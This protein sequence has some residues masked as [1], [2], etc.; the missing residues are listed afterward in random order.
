MSYPTPIY[1]FNHGATADKAWG[2]N[3]NNPTAILQYND[4]K[5]LPVALRDK[6]N[7]YVKAVHQNNLTPVNAAAT[8][9]NAAAVNASMLEFLRLK[10]VRG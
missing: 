5:D 8:R 10:Q 9:Q 1:T 6:I 4:T 7:N 2:A 3:K